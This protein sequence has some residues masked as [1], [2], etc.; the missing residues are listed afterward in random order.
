MTADHPSIEALGRFLAGGL[1]PHEAR[2]VLEHL[3]RRCELCVRTLRAVLARQGG[4]GRRAADYD[5][6]LAGSVERSAPRRA[7]IQA[8]RLEAAALWAL[9]LGTPPAQREKLVVADP[10]FHSWDLA[11]R[12]LDSA[13]EYH[14]RDTVRAIAACRLALAI[15]ERLPRSL[16][17][18]RLP[19]DLRARALGT[20]ADM[21]RLDDQLAA[22][23]LTLRQAWEDLD[24]G[25]GEPLELAALLRCDAN[26][27]LTLGEFAGA[28]ALL[29]SAASL[30]RF[31]GDSCE[32]GRTLQRLALALGYED[33]AQ[34]VAAA[35]RA[36]AILDPGREPR[37]VL[38][39]RHALIWFLNDG[40]HA[41]QALDQLERSRPLY[42]QLGETQPRL[43]MPWLEARICRRLGELDAAERGL[44]AVWHDFREAGF[45]QE[46]TLVSLDLAETYATRGK[47]RHAVRL[48]KACHAL[49]RQWSMHAAGIA[50]WLLLVEAAAGEA[51]RLQ[52]LTREAALYYRRAWRREL[53][54]PGAAPPAPGRR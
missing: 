39:A 54:F 35:E 41:W 50:A 37:L 40:G 36:L 8:D 43:L 23:E 42:R 51:G 16:Y 32:E 13:A 15:V 1:E 34:G 20:L 5:A 26:L 29:R 18:D 53:P 46:L 14:W 31:C 9:L 11:S 48:L 30:Y 19:H 22:A 21:L 3:A 27:R 7:A 45:H 17:R 44:A 47:A 33:P 4:A 6:V 38:A 28:A 10:R 2:P 49:L 25:T 52:A 12:L 24:A